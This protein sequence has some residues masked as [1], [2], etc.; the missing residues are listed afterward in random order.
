MLELRS[1]PLLCRRLDETQAQVQARTA[2]KR[3][4]ANRQLVSA[5]QRRNAVADIGE[6]PGLEENLHIVC[7]GNFPLWSIVPA[8]L[9]LAAPAVIDRLSIATLGFSKQNAAELLSLFD[10]GRVKSVAIVC[11]SYFEKQSPAEFNI[12]LDGLKERGQRIAALRAHAKIIAMALSDGGRF[13]V[14]SSAN[15]RSCRNIE[16]ITLINSKALHDFHAGWIDDVIA[17]AQVNP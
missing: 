16:Q 4:A 3:R 13:T 6:L 7:R 15:L 11:S 9:T 10:A 14:E 1:N 5:L 17:K 8:V 12:M 2:I